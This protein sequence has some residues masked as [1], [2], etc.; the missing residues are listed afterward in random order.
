MIC[1]KKRKEVCAVTILSHK[2]ISSALLLLSV[3]SIAPLYNGCTMSDYIFEWL[4]FSSWSEDGAHIS[5]IP[6]SCYICGVNLVCRLVQT[7]A[8]RCG[9]VSDLSQHGVSSSISPVT[10][11]AAFP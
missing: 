5:V 2:T 1:W 11:Y 6:G 10:E 3:M 9:A 4:G 7:D 8:S